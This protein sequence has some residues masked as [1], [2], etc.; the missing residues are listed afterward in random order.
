MLYSKII[1]KG[2]DILI[3]IHSMIN[4]SFFSAN[5]SLLCKALYVM[6]FKSYRCNKS[7]SKIH[8][9]SSTEIFYSQQL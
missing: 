3:L 9:F 7:V 4:D 2:P 8:V 5:M 1:P 6:K